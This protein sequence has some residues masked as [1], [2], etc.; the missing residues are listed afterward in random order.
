MHMD[1]N[2]NNFVVWGLD[3]ERVFA[4]QAFFFAAQETKTA[5]LSKW[6]QNNEKLPFCI[7]EL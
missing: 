1:F 5:A 4:I 3:G 2:I 6:C 7:F